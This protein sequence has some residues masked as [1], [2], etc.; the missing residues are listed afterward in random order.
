MKLFA[1]GLG[2]LWAF[3]MACDFVAY[4]LFIRRFAG[5][6][7]DREYLDPEES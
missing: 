5:E 7:G 4:L 6:Y 3:L 2:V 1:I